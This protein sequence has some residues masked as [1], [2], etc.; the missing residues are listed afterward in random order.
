MSEGKNLK[1]ALLI[2]FPI[3][4]FNSI[5]AAYKEA[6]RRE[7]HGIWRGINKVFVVTK[8][9][10]CIDG[11]TKETKEE[12]AILVFEYYNCPFSLESETFMED[13]R[14]IE[15][16]QNGREVIC[17]VEKTFLPPEKEKV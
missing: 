2:P 6:K 14:T 13:I 9:I 5:G 16:F 4:E 10:F 3:E 1:L 7:D 11:K 15:D 17:I 12:K 8:K